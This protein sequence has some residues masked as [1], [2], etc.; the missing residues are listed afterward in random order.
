[1]DYIFAADSMGPSLFKFYWWAPK[2]I[3]TERKMA[4]QGQSRVIQGR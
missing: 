4:V 3:V 2:D 1:M